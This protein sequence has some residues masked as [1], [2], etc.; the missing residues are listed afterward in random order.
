[1]KKDKFITEFD[2]IP[3]P[4]HKMRELSL[5]ERKLNFKEVELGFTEEE[6]IAEAKRCLSCRRC[7]GCG[8]CL[9]ECDP[10]AIIYDDKPETIDIKADAIILAPGFEE[11]N[12]RRIPELGYSK[13]YNVIT[14]IEFERI[15]SDNG[16]YGGLILRPFDGEIPEKIAFIQCV[17]SREEML[18]ANYCSSICC[19]NALKN[20]IEIKKR[21]KNTEV[22]IFHR[23]IRPFGKGSELLFIEAK[24][25]YTIDF[26][27]AEVKNLQQDDSGNI[28]IEYLQNNEEKKEKFDLVVLSTGIQA[29]RDAKKLSR[30]LKTGLNKYNFS[31]N[32]SFLP[33]YTEKEGVFTAGA[34]N[35][36]MDIPSC[37]AEAGNVVSHICS[38]LKN[39]KGKIEVSVKPEKGKYD[40]R[41]GIFLCKY[42]LKTLSKT[43]MM[44]FL[45]VID[46]LSEAYPV[47]KYDYA[48]VKKS[49]DDII[50]TI[51]EE[52][53]DRIIICSCYSES[54][55][56]LFKDISADAN[57][58]PEFVDVL[59]INSGNGG[60]LS[61]LKTLLDKKNGKPESKTRIEKV[62]SCM[63]IGG[64]VSGI[65]ASLK[66]AELGLDVFLVEK[67]E[68]LGGRLIDSY[69]LITGDEIKPEEKL[70]EL[71]EKV[72]NN[73]KIKV[74]LN[75]YI[76]EVKGEPGNFSV[77]IK[78]D[79]KFNE[80]KTGGIIVA[81]GTSIYRYSEDY[82]LSK[83][84]NKGINQ[85]ELE[86]L[87]AENKFSAKKVVMIQCVGA[88][89]YC[90]RLCCTEAI[91]N[92]LKIKQVS[93]DTDIIV[94]HKG[95]R[96][97]DFDEELYSEAIE[98]G[99]K[100]VESVIDPEVE[101]E[102]ENIRVK[103]FENDKKKNVKAIYDADLV[104][105]NVAS[106]PSE[107]NKKIADV[108]NVSL[109]K[110][111]FFKEIDPLLNPV[112]LDRE[113]IFVCGMAHYPKTLRECIIQ[114][115]AAAEKAFLFITNP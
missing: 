60:I 29:P 80:I 77:K 66:L 67:K 88:R 87:I 73:E 70:E 75:S 6:A 42:G 32:K 11:F 23:G 86:K 33:C 26:V 113:G 28:K 13:F 8:L 114:A 58:K 40:G 91:V 51:R 7:I 56:G 53:L 105:F 27:E 18:A 10:K 115:N 83:N 110:E 50:N 95:I 14:G 71:N 112:E 12:P 19:V 20:S 92:A 65:T 31:I 36:P 44:E 52:N 85:Y 35:G 46:E 3:T 100:F 99:V 96:V 24:E 30:M 49:T 68:K 16:P 82:A 84:K 111:M 62:K 43:E 74:I 108:L 103:V 45:G 89:N 109:D 63:I 101:E 78:S 39:K 72:N 97:F 2:D 104:V 54:H 102:G 47:K 90:S 38:M 64:G 41:T 34:F 57:L 17:G 48:C 21:L 22:K 59:D 106:I 93:P 9:A 5:E 69:Y 15:L 55:S 61:K 79:G 1:M 81:I 98:K 37:I 25:K 107:D 4:R 76:E 94:L